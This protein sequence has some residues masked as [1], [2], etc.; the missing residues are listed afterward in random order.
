MNKN[1][2]FQHFLHCEAVGIGQDSE[3]EK[4]GDFSLLEKDTLHLWSAQYNNL[5]SYFPFVSDFLSQREWEK[6]SQFLNPA[7]ARRYVLRHGMVRFIL[8][9]YTNIDPKFL[10]LVH[11]MNGKPGLYPQSKFH[12]LSFSLSHTDQIVCIGVTIHDRI[13]IDIVKNDPGYP[14]HHS[15]EYLFTPR[16]KEFM[17]G[18]EPGQRY[19]M[20]FRIWALKEAIVKATGD[21]IRMMSI[22]D[23]TNIIEDPGHAS[24]QI[25]KINEKP[26]DFFIYQFSP[27]TGYQGAAA[28]CRRGKNST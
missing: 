24:S 19:Q 5:N 27:D 2:N 3:M 25:V 9:N 20:F 8:G 7:D 15:I 10:P 18:I 21:G 12:E 14:F 6:S 23:V 17:L 26:M 22:T 13:G 4:S 1:N 28:I 16:E 11:D